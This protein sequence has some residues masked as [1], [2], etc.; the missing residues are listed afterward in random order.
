M[1]FFVRVHSLTRL[2]GAAHS[3]SRT[4]GR[5]AAGVALLAAL[6]WAAAGARA[7]SIFGLQPVGSASASQSVNV[8]VTQAGGGTVKTVEVLTAGAT[9]GDFAAGTGTSNC[10]GA[11]LAQNASCTESVSF[12]PAT[13]GQ[14]IGAVVLLDASGNVLGVTYISGVGSGGLGVLEQANVA[15]VA[16]VPG[17][18]STVA[19]GGPATQGQLNLPAGVTLDGYGNMYIADS[20]HDRIRMVCGPKAGT[21]FGFACTTPGTITTIVGNGKLGYAGDGGPAT[22]ATVTT[23]KAVAVDG[24]GNLYL[25]DTGNNRI[26]MVSAATDII[27]TVAGNGSTGDSNAG[28]VGDGGPAT[29]ANLSQPWDIKLDAYGN[30]YIADTFNHRVREVAAASGDISTIAGTGKTLSTGAG[31]FNGDNIAA[32]AAD[33]NYPYGIALDPAGNL[34]IA[35]SGNAR[36]RKVGA[37]GGTI[38][39]AS[40]I[41]TVA[42]TGTQGGS[43]ACTTLT[44]S[45]LA[46]QTPLLWPESVALDAAGNLYLADSQNAA[47][48]EVNVSNGMLSTVVQGNCGWSFNSGALI[49]P[50]LYG[51]TGLFLDG[52]GNLYLADYFNMVIKEVQGNY[53]ALNFYT[54]GPTRQGSKSAPQPQALENDG[55]GPLDLTAITPDANSTTD[56]SSTC[57]VGSPYLAP[58]ADCTTQVIFAPTAAGKPLIADVNVADNTIPGSPGIAAPNSPLDIKLIGYATAVNSTTT[59]VSSSL[60]PS[61]FGQN[62]TFT[63]AVNT[64]AGTGSLTGTVS[65]TDT[66]QGKTVTLASNLPLKL[67]SGGITGT[68]TY[69]TTALGVG[70]HTIVAAY[71]NT[72]D[73]NHFASTS[74]D[75][76]V[77]PLIQTVLEGTQTT[78]TSSQNPSTVGQSVKFTATVSS[79]GGTVTPDGSV[80][81]MDG[82]STLGPAQPL[83]AAGSDGVA[84]YTTSTLTNGLHQITA[85]YSGDANNQI[86]ASTSTALPQDVQATASMAL[87]SSLNPSNFGDNVTLTASMTSTATQPATGAVA[88][89]DN[90]VQI[91]TGTLAGNPAVA[92]FTTAGLAVGSHAI[93]ASYAG[94]A[95]NS[96]AKGA[97]P[98]PQV[99]NQAQTATSVMAVPSPG[100]AGG[101]ETIVATVTVTAGVLTPTGTVTFTSGGATLGAAPLAANGTA[102]I[103]PAL[104]P[105]NY[106]IVATYSGNTDAATSASAP[107]PL[108][109]NPATTLTALSISPNPGLVTRP[110]TFS[111]KVT[112]NGGTPTGN[113]NFMANG[114]SIGTGALNA[115]GVA[116]LVVSTLPVGA[117]TV[118][119]NYAGDTDDTASASAPQS[120]NVQLATT[121]TVLTIAPPQ[122][123]VGQTVTFTAK[124]T[125]NGAAPTGAVNFLSNGATLGTATVNAGVAT[126]TTSN[127]PAATYSV[128]ASYAGDAANAASASAP[129]PLTIGLIPTA[130]D[131]GTSTTSGANPQVILVATVL[132]G[133]T[134][135]MPSGTVKFMSGSTQLGSAT[136]ETS[137]VATLVPNLT[138]GVNYTITAVYSGDP[139]HSASSSQPVTVSGTASGFSIATQPT[140]ITMKTGQNATIQVNLTSSGGF[141]DTIAF[142]CGSLPAG[143]TCHFSPAS[144]NLG[145]NG[146]ATAQLTIDTNN[147]LSGGNSAMN[148]PASPGGMS[149][150]GFFLPLGAFFG[151]LFWRLRKRSAGLLTMALVL[152]L[153]A[154]AL[155]ATGCTGFSMGSV[156]PGTYTIQIIGTGTNSNVVHYQNETLDITQ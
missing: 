56:P 40:V 104:A 139:I 98:A 71:D 52:Y 4:R 2:P 102:T 14:R 6:T 99:V 34:Y 65:L 127:L 90:N 109:V 86:Q 27:T 23:P 72:N 55:N 44:A 103:K 51:P 152:A 87:I 120:F 147:P 101:P 125:G 33:L 17:Q 21:F 110:I 53:A 42:G 77:L 112:G 69:P 35:D 36:I 136:L 54:T 45:T 117:Y 124:V 43:N 50:Q 106:Q 156:Q 61:G 81:F 121:A 150:A 3:G 145:A 26:R 70:Q 79:T 114:N 13:P 88:F 7:Q 9:G 140:S 105:G 146:S 64:G 122:A 22:A 97:L 83:V 68:A 8:T 47:I 38:T 67:G 144:A 62:V 155:L 138:G 129:E 1:S 82:G 20:E 134:G 123:L 24:A 132:N 12:T 96:A 94:D 49:H 80:Q 39:A 19:D 78:L 153:S 108:T 119:A 18:Y 73:P 95:Y 84:T 131:L 148:H 113:V 41:T 25:A 48:R 154:A 76:G 74:T 10:P 111:A 63:I 133:A 29:A 37:V 58:A 116:S 15:V 135:P 16:G 32:I 126:F 93:T 151:W 141:S 11:T 46:N 107:L 142:G 91:G 130:T 149:M 59:T 143:A 57:A 100:I 75:N 137:G 5:Q 85:V 89:F 28:N 128:T 115:S 31:D 92:S 66:Y 118:T 30:L 60:N